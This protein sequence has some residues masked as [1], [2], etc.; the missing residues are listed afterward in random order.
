MNSSLLI[1][2]LS[3]AS[4]LL[5]SLSLAE[6]SQP[7]GSSGPA[8]NVDD[9]FAYVNTRVEGWNPSNLLQHPS[10]E[11]VAYIE[12]FGAVEKLDQWLTA[13]SEL[14]ELNLICIQLSDS[15]IDAILRLPKLTTLNLRGCTLSNEQLAQLTTSAT[16]R[17]LDL[18][19]V[20]LASP[21]A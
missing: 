18:R 10:P 6:S 9:Q 2:G 16:I 13:H 3:A 12:G 8:D 5:S 7:R 4:F 17:E 1:A 20:S 11:R 21:D 19:G 15:D 14:A